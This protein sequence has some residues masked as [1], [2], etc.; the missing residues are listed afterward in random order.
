VA[1][2]Y[3]FF[4]AYSAAQSVG[5]DYYDF[6]P[7]PDGRVA[8]VLGDVAGK[9]VPASLLMAKLSAESRFCM[10]TQTDPAKAVMLLND[11]LIRGGIGDRFVTLAAVIL[12]PAENSCS[13]VNAGHINPFIFRSGE[14][15]IAEAC[16]NAQSGLPLGIVPGFPY[17]TVNLTF[18]PGDYLLIFTDGVT[19]SAAPE[20]ELFGFDG[21]KKILAAGPGQPKAVVEQVLAAV[22]KHAAGRAQSDDIAIVCFGR[23]N[24]PGTATHKTA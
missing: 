22:R 19:D 12:N 20:G 24:D 13:L 16:T 14:K 4:A 18:G 3:E 15:S 23:V 7:L 21:I 9:G 2:G 6:I 1:A 11:T 10:L 5:G 8:V 17:E